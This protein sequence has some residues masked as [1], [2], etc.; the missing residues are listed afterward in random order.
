MF[1]VVF[2]LTVWWRNSAPVNR[3]GPARPPGGAPVTDGGRAEQQGQVEPT[4]ASPAANLTA[5]AVPAGGRGAQASADSATPVGPAAAAAAPPG[6][7]AQPADLAPPSPDEVSWPLAGQVTVPFGWIYSDTMADWRHHGGLDIAAAAG[8]PIR[9]I[10]PGSV[11]AVEFDAAWGWRVTVTH[12]PGYSSIYAGCDR[13]LV[14]AGSRVEA[15]QVLAQVGSSALSETGSAA[16]L[17]FELVWDDVAV[18]P[19]TI[20]PGGAS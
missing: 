19:L 8:E 4:A 14:E 17:H 6:T 7:L 13:V 12:G 11:A 15:G 9:A 20:L 5:D 16:H 2:G 18:D 1:A 10:L 3:P